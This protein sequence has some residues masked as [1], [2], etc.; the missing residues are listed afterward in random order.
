MIFHENGNQKKSGIA[1]LKL[2]KINFKRKVVYE[3]QK[4]RYMMIK[5]SLQRFDICEYL[6]TQYRST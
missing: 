4:G 1:L 6:C 2:D 5:G 3:R